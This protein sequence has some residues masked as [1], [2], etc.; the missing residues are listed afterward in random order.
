MLSLLLW[1]VPAAAQ[2]P[3]SGSGIALGVRGAYGIAL[4][5]VFDDQKLS[6]LVGN[7]VAPQVDLA[8]FLSRQLSLGAYFQYGFARGVQ[9]IVADETSGRV[10]RFGF[11]L[12][13]H[14]TPEAFVAPWV[15]VGMGY[16]VASV[17]VD[18]LQFDESVPTAEY[19][20]IEWGHAHFGV[21]FQLTRSFA[22]GP[23]VTAT[24][25]QYTKYAGRV[26]DQPIEE[27]DISGDSRAFH[28]WIQPGVRVQFRL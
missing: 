3:S 6:F 1:G 28:F 18:F 16:E 11:D 19:K 5:K 14:F 9:G 26:L 17:D 22:V 12:D 7:T 25:G 15:G 2:E 27:G 8:Y 13:Y 24:L 23:Y 10:L 4:G 21:D 20:G